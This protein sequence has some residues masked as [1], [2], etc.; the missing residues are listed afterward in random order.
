VG[1]QA[2]PKI[3]A[4]SK[5]TEEGSGN[6]NGL[7]ESW[8]S[9][10]LSSR[11]SEGGKKIKGAPRVK[12]KKDV[13]ILVLIHVDLTGLTPLGDGTSRRLK[14]SWEPRKGFRFPLPGSKG[15][16]GGKRVLLRGFG[17]QD[18]P[19]VASETDQGDWGRPGQRGRNFVPKYWRP[20]RG[21]WSTSFGKTS[22]CY[23]EK[24]E[25]RTQQL[26]RQKILRNTGREPGNGL[27]DQR[28]RVKVVE[29][30]GP[31]GI[32][33][34]RGSNDQKVKTRTPENASKG[35]GLKKV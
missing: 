15:K 18:N 9:L 10:E 13:A 6:R 23:E 29:E 21:K 33:E 26:G 16:G 14:T 34:A 7:R 30:S 4:P 5:G 11:Q 28:G 12:E 1:F 19:F 27:A 22:S 24:R 2:H 25:L 8:V 31:R 32:G 20:S 3:E 17:L 35:G